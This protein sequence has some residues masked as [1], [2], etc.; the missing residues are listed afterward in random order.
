MRNDAL[1]KAY[2]EAEKATRAKSRFLAAASHDLRQPLHAMSLFARAL[3]RRVSGEEAPRLVNQL[4]EALASLREMFEA[5]L[6]IS[7]LDAGLIQPDVTE[8]STK[9]L[10]ERVASGSRVEAEG[11]GLRF[12]SRSVDAQLRTD[13]AL[14]GPCCAI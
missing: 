3:S 6:N 1:A 4:E 9:T 2:A 12:L 11:R 13:P 7:R 14:L 10:V 8:V 5:L